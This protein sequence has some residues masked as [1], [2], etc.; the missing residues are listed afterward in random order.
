M[1]ALPSGIENVPMTGNGQPQP[2][3]G[4][5]GRKRTDNGRGIRIVGGKKIVE[6]SK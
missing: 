2:V 5:D 6:T 4:L 1:Q 3:Y